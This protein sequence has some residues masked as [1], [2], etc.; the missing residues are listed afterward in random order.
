MSLFEESIATMQLNSKNKNIPSVPKMGSKF[1]PYS[2]KDINNENPVEVSLIKSY[3]NNNSEDGIKKSCNSDSS[4]KELYSKHYTK[5]LNKNDEL[6]SQ[7]NSSN[8]IVYKETFDIEAIRDENCVN[9]N[10][11][12]ANGSDYNLEKSES[13]HP[14]QKVTMDPCSKCQSRNFYKYPMAITP[15][16]SERT[17]KEIPN[18]R[19]SMILNPENNINWILV[20]QNCLQIYNSNQ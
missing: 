10:V 19:Y 9:S 7:A 1:V 3:Q 16:P 4:H 20:C 11:N 18:K 8:N 15:K 17:I 2:N 5:G 13:K 12:E 14:V 6:K